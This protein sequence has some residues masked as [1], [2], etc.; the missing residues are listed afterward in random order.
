MG[1]IIGTFPDVNFKS[2]DIRGDDFTKILGVFDYQWNLTFYWNI[3]QSRAYMT[4]YIKIHIKAILLVTIY[5]ILNT[6]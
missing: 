2:I 6:N 4:F 1:P 5:L 3:K